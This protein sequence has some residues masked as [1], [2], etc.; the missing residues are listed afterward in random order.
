[1]N[2]IRH[3]T[4]TPVAA[5]EVLEVRALL[6]ASPALARMPALSDPTLNFAALAQQTGN[7]S[8]GDQ[9]GNGNGSGTGSGTGSDSDNPAS[10]FVGQYKGFIDIRDLPGA[11]RPGGGTTGGNGSNNS[12][13]SGSGTGTGTDN[14]NASD[15]GNDFQTRVDLRLSESQ[16]SGILTGVLNT[17]EMGSYRVTG[18]ASPSR[19]LILILDAIGNDDDN[20][21]GSN[22]N[23][24]RVIGGT[25]IPPFNNNGDNGGNNSANENFVSSG[26][27]FYGIPRANGQYKGE[28]VQ[29]VQ[30][31]ELHGRMRLNFLG[32]DSSNNG[33]NNNNN[34]GNNG[35]GGTGTGTGT[36]KGT[37]TGTGTGGSGSSAQ[38]LGS[39]SSAFAGD[40]RI[41]TGVDDVAADD[42]LV[43]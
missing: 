9:T 24:G 5:F 35:N 15:N 22:N 20:G 16:G 30:G 31:R 7:G 34:G 41:I 4:A 1:M 37:G 36:G 39:G 21:S 12:G 28:I 25:I 13:G 11:L 14:G 18:F 19:R 2:S 40:D 8:T 29:N 3:T 10:R 33:G 43:L 38:S 6:S 17:R 42:S 23:T 26:A 32:D 27:L